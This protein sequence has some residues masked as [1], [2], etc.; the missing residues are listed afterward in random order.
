MSVVHISFGE[1]AY[2]S[3]KKSLQESIKHQNEQI[4]CIYEDFSIG[5]IYKIES[6]E[7]IKER[8]Q[9]LNDLLIKTG[10]ASD[11]S[12]LDWIETTL[13]NN[14]HIVEEI[15]NDSKVIIWHGN[16]ASDAIGLRFV[17]FSLQNKR[18]QFE[19]VNVTEYGQHIAYKVV[20]AQNKEI[21]YVI[22][23]LGEMPTKFILDALQTKRSLSHAE[24]E[25]LINEWEKWSRTKD[26]LRILLHGKVVAVS[27]DYYD[28]FILENTSNEYQR[29]A[30][31]VGEVMGK[32]EQCIGDTY[33]TFRVHQMIRQ[34][35]LK[36]RGDSQFIGKRE[37]RLA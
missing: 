11:E 28:E 19:E 25:G 16:N 36:Y 37:I 24:K 22:K 1:S 13:K 8:K 21:P 14:V 34:G 29:V 33:L 26:V 23:S 32:H 31:V 18:I 20:D 4:I 35:K 10:P 12:Y 6:N 15:P 3:L 30:R 2:G 17:A 27:E 9:W 5:P 7:G